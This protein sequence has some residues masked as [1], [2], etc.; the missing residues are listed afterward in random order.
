MRLKNR[1]ALI[2][3]GARGIGLGISRR[4]ASEGALAIIGDLQRC[5]EIGGKVGKPGVARAGAFA[6]R[7]QID[8]A[9]FVLEAAL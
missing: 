5:G 3:G 7:A 8:P 6:I 1:V 2:T 9:W 4:L